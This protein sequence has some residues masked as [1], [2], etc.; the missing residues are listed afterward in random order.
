MQTLHRLKRVVQL[1]FDGEI[2]S[3]AW[4]AAKNGLKRS[5][6][7]APFA[8]SLTQSETMETK[9]KKAKAVNGK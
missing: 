4:I 8:Q 2:Y 9:S 3:L 6:P 7:P 1:I 5:Q